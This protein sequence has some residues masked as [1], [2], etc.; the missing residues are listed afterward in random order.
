MFD[1]EASASYHHL[2]NVQRYTFQAWVKRLSP[3]TGA[4]E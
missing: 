3:T 1:P 2:K 4:L